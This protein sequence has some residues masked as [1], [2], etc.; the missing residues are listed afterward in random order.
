MKRLLGTPDVRLY[1]AATWAKYAGDADYEQALHCDRNH[2]LSPLPMRAPYWHVEGFLFL[3]D[4]DQGCGPTHIADLEHTAG[5]DVESRPTRDED[6][7]LYRAE[8][9]ATG[10]RG[11][12]LFYRPDVFHRGTGMTRKGASRFLY[13]ISYKP[14]GNDLVH[15]NTMQPRV[16]SPEFAAFVSSL[17]RQQ[18]AAI[19]FP[20]PG[21]PMWDDE[22][23]DAAQRRYPDMDLAPWRAALMQKEEAHR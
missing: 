17:D 6:P 19:G 10:P 2:S 21:D 15:F 16:G 8:Q 5:R 22:H 4:I 20:P 14:A 12:M 1:Q 23:I 13:N 7:D 3:S 11:S 18:L 9:A